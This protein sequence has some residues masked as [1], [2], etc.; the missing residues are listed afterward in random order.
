[1]NYVKRYLIVASAMLFISAGCATDVHV[2]S[3]SE[4]ARLVQADK[5]AVLW[6]SGDAEVAHK[7]CSLTMRK[8]WIG[9]TRCN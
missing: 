1:M 6:S 5:L 9:L 2:D 3:T 4:P 8:D 7:V